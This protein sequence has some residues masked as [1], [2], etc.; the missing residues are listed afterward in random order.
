MKPHVQPN[1]TEKRMR[2]EDFIVSKTDLK[3]NITYCNRTFQEFAGH[4]EKTLLGAP[5]NIIRH[6]D[7]PRGLFKL[8]WTELA[9]GHEIQVYVKNLSA[10]GSYYWVF[11]TMTPSYD[12]SGHVIGYYSVRR[13][14]DRAAV[15][16]ME[17][18]Y[19]QMKDEEARVHGA[20]QAD[21]S[22]TL[23]NRI[24]SEKEISYANFIRSI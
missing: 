2:D 13:A 16:I 8:I 11:A 12:A 10:D 22:L 9:A 15:K 17:A 18:L 19:R 4:E 24:L 1:M 7:M 6:P 20:A 3:G 5:H 14:P 21:A 23:L